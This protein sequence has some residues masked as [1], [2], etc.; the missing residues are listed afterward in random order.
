MSG[1][2]PAVQV[3]ADQ[4]A[5]RA[6]ADGWRRGA[7]RLGRHR[8]TFRVGAALRAAPPEREGP[9]LSR[10]LAGGAS[11]ARADRLAVGRA[12]EERFTPASVGVTHEVQE[13]GISRDPG[14]A[15]APG[16]LFVTDRANHEPPAR[17]RV[18]HHQGQPGRQ[19][20]PRLAQQPRPLL[21]VAAPPAP[22]T[23]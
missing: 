3:E 12:T 19:M 14:R 10:G 16:P 1:C 18:F 21:H 22:V 5:L 9:R 4:L 20:A 7:A 2:A 13:A 8:F 6:L 23:P 17:A 15:N 11:S